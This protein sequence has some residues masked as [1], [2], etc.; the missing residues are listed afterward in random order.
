MRKE[1][2]FVIRGFL[3]G[4]IW[5]PGAECWKDLA[6]RFEHDKAGITKSAGYNSLRDAL[7][8]ATNDGDFRT[9]AVAQG[10]LVIHRT[11]Y[12]ATSRTIR[13]RAFPL[14]MF[15]GI[16][17]LTREWDGPYEENEAA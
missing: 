1:T 7:C 5:Q 14:S 8:A 4:Y 12:T 11:T 15:R 2:T 17:D 16:E 13:S 10:E 9:C 3:V 6:F